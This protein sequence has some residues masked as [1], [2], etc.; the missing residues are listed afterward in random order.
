M[1]LLSII[2]TLSTLGDEQAAAGNLMPVT[3]QAY[4]DL[5]VE[6]AKKDLQTHIDAL[7][8]GHLKAIAEV[9]RGDPASIIVKNA[10]QIRRR[11]DH[12]EH[13]SQSRHGSILGAQCCSSC[14]QTDKITAFANT[15][16]IEQLARFSDIKVPNRI[17]SFR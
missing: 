6:N 3:T 7:H 17:F 12:L 14:C 2:P 5:K 4:L 11:H 1:H 16:G 8:K 15:T 13:T 9:A 10:E